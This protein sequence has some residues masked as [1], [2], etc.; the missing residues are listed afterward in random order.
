M[1]GAAG[2]T[3]VMHMPVESPVSGPAHSR[4]QRIGASVAVLLGLAGIARVAVTLPAATQGQ[5]PWLL[6]TVAV[7]VLG[8]YYFLMTATTTVDAEGIVQTGLP[9]RR[10]RWDDV[11]YARVGGLP[12]ARRLRVRT[13]SGRRIAFAGASPALLAA[14]ERVAAAFPLR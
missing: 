10:V 7:A 1:D 13:T 11:A 12:F 5:G 4:T 6:L 3:A 2:V 9:N 8:S 14:F